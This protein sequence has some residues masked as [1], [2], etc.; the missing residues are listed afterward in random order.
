L[1]CVSFRL[2][3][4]NAATFGAV[5]SGAINIGTFFFF[6]NFCYI[7][8]G[9]GFF[10]LFTKMK[11]IINVIILALMFSACHFCQTFC[12]TSFC[13]VGV[14]W[15]HISE[16]GLFGGLFGVTLALGFFLA[17][18]ING[19][20]KTQAH[21][22]AVLFLPGVVLTVTG[23]LVALFVKSSPEEAGYIYIYYSLYICLLLLL[24]WYILILFQIS[25]C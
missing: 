6:V 5:C 3:G 15:Y 12:T 2:G 17:F 16:R 18:E 8:L 1:L 21:Y 14:Y 20:V 25:S 11:G 19:T 4:R 9:M 23:V 22:S 7:N 10:V 13:K 24:L